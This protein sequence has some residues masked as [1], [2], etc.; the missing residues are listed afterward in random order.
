MIPTSNWGTS[1][2]WIVIKLG[3][4]LDKYVIDDSLSSDFKL[5]ALYELNILKTVELGG[6]F[7]MLTCAHKQEQFDF[8]NEYQI[9]K[10]RTMYD[11]WFGTQQSTL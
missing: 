4:N 9:R 1:T 8:I 6:M 2:Q 10:V 11:E 3:N 7:I 5:G